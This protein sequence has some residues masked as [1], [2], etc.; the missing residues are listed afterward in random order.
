MVRARHHQRE[1]RA[2]GTH[3]KI[4]AHSMSAPAHLG[5]ASRLSELDPFAVEGGGTPGLARKS[6]GFGTP[7]RTGLRFHRHGQHHEATVSVHVRDFAQLF[8]SL[9][10]S[11]LWN[12]DLDRAV[13][14]FIEDEFRDRRS[15]GTW[16]LQVFAQE[17]TA[18]TADLQSA[19]E[20]YYRR[21]AKSARLALREHFR[22]SRIALLGGALIFLLST[23]ARG[24][25][26]GALREPPVLLDQ[27]L[28]IL[29]WLGLWRPI[30]ALIYEWV[31]FYR[32]RRLYERLAKV[33]VT[34]RSGTAG[35]RS[36]TPTPRSSGASTVAPATGASGV[37]QARGAL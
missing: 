17:A 14:E 26:D 8:N 3:L 34:V 18:V 35:A 13:A 23:V 6:A 15:V 11:P 29:A 36:G 27:G 9:D 20:I 33:R 21:L 30:E 24:I 32:R 12:R 16:R 5:P 7:R 22:I 28:I 31:P 10:P 1:E 4:G 25:I 37:P 2:D 19:V